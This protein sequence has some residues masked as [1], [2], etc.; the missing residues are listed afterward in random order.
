MSFF[1]LRVVLATMVFAVTLGGQARGARDAGSPQ[2]ST[3]RIEILVFEVNRC[4]Y[5]RIFRR[6]VL[7]KYERSLRAKKAP[8][9]FINVSQTDV[10]P[11]K[12]SAPLTMAPT[13]V[14]MQ[15]GQERGRIT[16][17]MGPEPFFHMVSQIMRG[18]D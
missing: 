17:Y 6:D 9:R 12:L 18:I 8:I 11:L 2:A 3:T 1:I 16:G 7:P 15:D 14:V 5:C 13:V 4:V 10:T